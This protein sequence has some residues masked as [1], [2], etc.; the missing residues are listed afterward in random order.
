M[1]RLP[2]RDAPDTFHHLMNRAL[3]KRTLFEGPADHRFFLSLV[4]REVRAGR[5]EVHAYCNM[6]THFHILV[7]SVNGQLSEAMRRIQHRYTRHFNRTRGRDGPLFRGRFRSFPVETLEHRRNVVSYIHDNPVAAAVLADSTLHR[8]SS[9]AHLTRE[10]RPVWLET[11]WTDAEMGA[12]GKGETRRDRL[13]SAFPIKVE[14]D[15][16]KWIE[17]SFRERQPDKIEDVVLAHAGN[18]R[19]VRWG[20]RKAK[21][22][23]GTRPWRPVCIAARVDRLLRKA[24]GKLGPILGLF[25]SATKDAWHALRAGL[26][27]MLAGT[28]H[29]EIG[30]R[31]GRHPGTSGRDV[32]DHARLLRDHARYENLA[33]RLAALALAAA[34]RGHAPRHL[35]DAG[36][37]PARA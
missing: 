2:R 17:R 28:T 19:V 31:G 18:A 16:R 30:M 34:R 26:L 33:A 37:V 20:F 21:L 35:V 12:R 15:F 5:I 23:D 32:R 10:R 27:R 22:A 25:K 36:E 9:A 24:R 6:L 13:L 14:E 4:A 7:R 11:S 29:D 1:P 3:A 8:W